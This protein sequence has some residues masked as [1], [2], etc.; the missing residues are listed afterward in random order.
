MSPDFEIGDALRKLNELKLCK[1]V[2]EN[3]KGG[4]IWQAP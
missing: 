1:I 2:G 3:E 4:E